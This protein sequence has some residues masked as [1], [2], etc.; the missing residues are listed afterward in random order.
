MAHLLL[1]EAGGG[2]FPAFLSPDVAEVCGAEPPRKRPRNGRGVPIAGPR[3]ELQV[4]E[5]PRS[6]LER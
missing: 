6:P 4:V 5:G 3:K 1:G 2:S